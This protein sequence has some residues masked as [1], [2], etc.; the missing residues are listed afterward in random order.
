[1]KIAVVA[2]QRR[3]FAHYLSN[4]FDRR[5][6]ILYFVSDGGG[7]L[8][9]RG[10]PL[11]ACKFTFEPHFLFH[12]QASLDLDSD[13]P[14]KHVEHGSLFRSERPWVVG[15]QHESYQPILSIQ[16]IGYSSAGRRQ[17]GM[18]FNDVCLKPRH[19]SGQNRRRAAR[20]GGVQSNYADAAEIETVLYYLFRISSE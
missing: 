8:A 15:N 5:K 7:K 19:L 6:R 13:L 4:D 3:V 1:M 10:H 17:S 14:G 18:V 11:P 16:R 2:I 20:A 12:E 9:K